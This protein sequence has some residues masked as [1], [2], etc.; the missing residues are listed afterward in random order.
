MLW[1]NHLEEG[2]FVPHIFWNIWILFLL[3]EALKTIQYHQWDDLKLWN[4]VDFVQVATSE[5]IWNDS[6]Y[7]ITY[8]YNHI[9][10]FLLSR[11]SC[12]CIKSNGL[13]LSTLVHVLS[14]KCYFSCSST[15]PAYW[16]ISKRLLD[17]SPSTSHWLLKYAQGPFQH[18]SF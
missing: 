5:S 13:C 14:S 10:I 16:W 17:L 3:T 2:G 9:L 4:N 7:N 6:T 18:L 12:P 1:L 8:K 11:F 15:Y